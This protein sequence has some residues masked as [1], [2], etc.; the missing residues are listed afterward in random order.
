[1]TTT[2]SQ[3]KSIVGFE[4]IVSIDGDCCQLV[5]T[6][7]KRC[8]VLLMVVLVV[9]EDL[10]DVSQSVD[11]VGQKG[12]WVGNYC[13]S[14][15]TVLFSLPMLAC[16]LILVIKESNVQREYVPMHGD[17]VRKANVIC[18]SGGGGGHHHHHYPTAQSPTG[19]LMF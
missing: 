8:L 9:L 6:T 2:E 7:D 16:N 4:L 10:L 5:H 13:L 14:I 15:G 3:P 19:L 1:M 12:V 17:P 11:I 18:K